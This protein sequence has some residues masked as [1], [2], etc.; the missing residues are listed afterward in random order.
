MRIVHAVVG[1]WLAGLSVG[2]TGGTARA[3]DAVVVVQGDDDAPTRRRDVAHVAVAPDDDCDRELHSTCETRR[4]RTS[5]RV[6]LGG[7]VATAGR[8]A[9][10]GLDLGLEM[11][12]GVVG[13]RI[14][15][16][17]LQGANGDGGSGAGALAGGLSQ[18]LAEV[19]VDGRPRGALHPIAAIGLG[20]AHVGATASAAGGNAGVGTARV[21][22]AY[23]LPIEGA[24]VRATVSV[25]GALPGPAE[26]GAE[27][28][29]G[30]VMGVAGLGVG[31]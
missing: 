18:Y 8:G 24:D 29:R 17:W 13:A 11:G 28:L 1:I 20:L 23:A 4:T 5:A 6:S 7:A 27:G 30:Y 22:I 15:A 26:S 14:G 10:P 19:T 3:D 31:F 9:A 25:L 2:V 21:G 12:G 16:S